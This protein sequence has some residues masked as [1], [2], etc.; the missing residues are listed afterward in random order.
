MLLPRLS[1]NFTAARF[2]QIP[3]KLTVV[4]EAMEEIDTAPP[5]VVM[6]SHAI[7]V[8]AAIVVGEKEPATDT[9]AGKRKHGE[10]ATSS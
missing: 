1:F 10:A 3:A 2:H 8:N 4:N 9:N 6:A 7:V 5:I